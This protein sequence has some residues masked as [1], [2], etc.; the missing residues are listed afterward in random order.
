[1][2]PHLPQLVLRSQSSVERSSIQHSY[3]S[4]FIYRIVPRPHHRCIAQIWLLPLQFLGRAVISGL[5]ALSVYCGQG[6]FCTPQK[7]CVGIYIA[8]VNVIIP[9]NFVR[10]LFDPAILTSILFNCFY[11]CT[12][13]TTLDL[14]H[15][16]SLPHFQCY[17]VM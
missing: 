11:T 16:K 10:V 6:C 15:C 9:T 17:N 1:M 3:S 8:I 5:A 14:A 4:Q 13:L 2:G 12:K 7:A